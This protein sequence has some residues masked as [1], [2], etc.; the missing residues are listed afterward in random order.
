MKKVTKSGKSLFLNYSIIWVLI[1]ITIALGSTEV[2]Y[3]DIISAGIML[4]F[5]IRL[6][7]VLRK[8]DLDKDIIE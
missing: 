1:A 3:D 7:L 2:L 6:A 5:V 4:I 8:T